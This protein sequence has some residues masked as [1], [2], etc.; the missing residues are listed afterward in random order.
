[1]RT[2]CEEEESQ[3]RR[4]LELAAGVVLHLAV[5]NWRLALNRFAL[6]FGERMP[7]L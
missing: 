3:K 7:A 1:M 2:K 5:K 4:A 6:E